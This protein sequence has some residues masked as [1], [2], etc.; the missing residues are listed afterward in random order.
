MSCETCLRYGHIV[1]RCHKTIATCEKCSCQGHIK[2]K[3]TSTGVRCCHCRDDHQAFSRNYQLFKRETEIVQIQT[4]ERIPRQQVIRKLLR[5]NPHPEIIFSNA[6]KNTSIQNQS[7]RLE[8]IN[9]VNPSLANTT[10][11]LYRLT[12]MDTI[13]R[14]KGKR[15]GDRPPHR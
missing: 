3:C 4:K 15:K 1:K 12:A 14:D 8:Q 11:L 9:K 5:I 7:P 2:Y 6:V 13:L 10:H